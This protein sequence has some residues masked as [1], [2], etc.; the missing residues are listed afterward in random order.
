MTNTTGTGLNNVYIGQDAAGSADARRSG[1][2]Y[3]GVRAG[4]YDA[5]LIIK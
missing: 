4:Q 5:I 1:N 2:T 3:V